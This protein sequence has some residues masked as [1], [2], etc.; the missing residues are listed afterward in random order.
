MSNFITN[1]NEKALLLLQTNVTTGFIILFIWTFA[2]SSFFPIPPDFVM[3]GLVHANPDKWVLY[4]SLVTVASVTGALFGYFIGD[5]AGRPF[6]KK[7]IK[8]TEEEK[9]AKLGKVEK[10]F[11]DYE[12]MAILIASLTPIPYKVFT[13]MGGIIEMPLKGFIFWSI[14]GR[15]LRFFI[16]AY[17][18]S[19]ISRNNNLGT[20]I[21]S[22]IELIFIA[23][24]L[25]FVIGFSIQIYMK[26][27]KNKNNQI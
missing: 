2:E 20:Y 11:K 15:G 23:I 24:G 16:G 19:I 12:N 18:F 1:F 25:V 13:I 26:R 17:L 14:I 3:W 6:L 10:L 27:K 4:A 9:N 5:K 21:K 7:F 8:G 22:N